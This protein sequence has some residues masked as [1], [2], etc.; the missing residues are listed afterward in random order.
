MYIHNLTKV[1]TISILLLL[2]SPALAENST[3]SGDYTVHHNALKS[4]FLSPAIAKTYNIQRSKFRGLLNISVIK[5][6]PGT[7]GTSVKARIELKVANLNNVPK[8]IELKQVVED[9]AIY[10]IGDFPVVNR[11]IVNFNLEVIPEGQSRP[12]SARFSQQFYID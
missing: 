10:Y 2:F 6:K 1:C 3:S 8:E 9:Q 7:T 11:E 12:I 5:N 4:D